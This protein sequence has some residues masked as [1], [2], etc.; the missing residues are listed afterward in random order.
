M[1]GQLGIVV[2]PC[3]CGKRFDC[4]WKLLTVVGRQ[5]K[6]KIVAIEG[7]FCSPAILQL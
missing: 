7:R 3:W 2:R 6:Y 1:A 5:E 4:H